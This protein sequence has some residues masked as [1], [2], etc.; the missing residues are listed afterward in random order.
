MKNLYEISISLQLS[1]AVLLLLWSFSKMSKNVLNMCFPGIVFASRRAN[2]D[3]YIDRNIIRSKVKTILLNVCAFCYITL[4]YL[5]PIFSDSNTE[6]R[7]YTFVS[8]VVLTIIFIVGA[9]L[10]S[11][12]VSIVWIRKD[13]TLTDDEIAEYNIPSEAIEQEVL[14][15]FDRDSAHD[16]GD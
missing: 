3:T 16:A 6:N 7:L 13:R 15:L 10:I 14:A 8:V 5:L 12:L 9:H 4:G 1:G 2:G 11:K